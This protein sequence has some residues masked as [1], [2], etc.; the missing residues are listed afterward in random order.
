MLFESFW[1]KYS[2]KFQVILNNIG[3]HRILMDNEVTLAHITEAYAA[4]ASAS[5]KY[6][7]DQE[8]DERT[9]FHLIKNSLSPQLYDAQ[10][11]RIRQRCSVQAGEWLKRDTRFSDWHDTS[12]QSARVLWLSGIPGAGI[13][14]AIKLFAWKLLINARQNISIIDD[15]QRVAK[16]Q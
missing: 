11:E 15:N 3:Q 4:R 7:R 5:A 13:A 9:E 10:L 16:H 8:Y 12:N 14:A 1:P 2:S 6:V